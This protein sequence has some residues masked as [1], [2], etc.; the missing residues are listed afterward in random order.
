[1]SGTSTHL[2]HVLPG[3]HY[4]R[5]DAV[6]GYGVGRDRTHSRTVS[7]HPPR[8]H[9]ACDFH[10][11]R[12]PHERSYGFWGSPDYEV[13]SHFPGALR[14][15]PPGITY[16]ACLSRCGP[17]PCTWLSHAPS[18]MAT[19]TPGMGIGGL[20]EGFPLPHVSL[21]LTSHTSSP[22][23]TLIDSNEV[24]EVA[25]IFQPIPSTTVPEWAWGI[26]TVARPDSG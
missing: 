16:F 10:R 14:G 17:S 1:L 23:F 2:T 4:G 5:S 12:R 20:Q 22:M 26:G 6:L 7:S 19:L 3:T 15:I 25:V 18:T 24:I 8:C 21:S 11:T 9:R 13:D